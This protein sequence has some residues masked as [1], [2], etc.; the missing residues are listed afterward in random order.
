[1]ELLSVL[2]DRH[3]DFDVPTLLT[4]HPWQIDPASETDMP[5]CIHAG[6]IRSHRAYA[7]PPQSSLTIIIVHTLP[8]QARPCVKHIC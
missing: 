5:A 3:D 7:E 2:S 8:R 4:N 6:S 1:M